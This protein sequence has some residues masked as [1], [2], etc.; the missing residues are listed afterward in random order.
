MEEAKARVEREAHRELE[1]DLGDPVK[2]SSADEEILEREAE[3]QGRDDRL[4]R[5]GVA[6][7][8]GRRDQ[9]MRLNFTHVAADTHGDAGGRR[10]K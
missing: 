5:G 8:D 7:R 9:G 6:H 10:P 1:E 2:A 4:D 3:N